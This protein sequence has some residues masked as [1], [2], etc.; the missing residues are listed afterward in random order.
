MPPYIRPLAIC[1]FHNDGKILVNHFQDGAPDRSF[2]RPIGGGIEF[3]ERSRDAVVREVEEELGL[4]IHNV[5]LIGTLE[6][7]F[8]YAGKPGHEIVQ[9]YDARF[10]DAAVYE[11]PWLA[12]CESDGAKFR[13]VWCG[14]LSFTEAAR[15]VPE[16]LLEL[17]VTAGLL[18]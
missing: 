11:K 16:G 9:V 4:A 5:Q 8:T 15:L 6:S 14:S 18:R 2:F 12:G 10:D 17:L 1:I 7:I 13:A 3:G